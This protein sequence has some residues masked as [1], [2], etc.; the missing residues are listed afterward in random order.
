VTFDLFLSCRLT[1]SQQV[2]LLE[3][4][5]LAA[6]LASAAQG[7]DLAIHAEHFQGDSKLLTL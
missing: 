5:S 4:S 1:E 6:D 2:T 7:V 3:L